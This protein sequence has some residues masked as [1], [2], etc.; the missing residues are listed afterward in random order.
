MQ[1]CLPTG[2]DQLSVGPGREGSSH[3]FIFLP[4]GL[5]SSR[6]LRQTDEVLGP[7]KHSSG[8]PGPALQPSVPWLDGLS[9]MFNVISSFKVYTVGQLVSSRV[10]TLSPTVSRGPSSDSSYTGHFSSSCCAGCCSLNHPALLTLSDL[11]KK[12]THCTHAKQRRAWAGT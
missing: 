4:P 11:K 7:Q 5:M 1:T 8:T 9:H 10:S 6:R 3:L 2:P 12:P